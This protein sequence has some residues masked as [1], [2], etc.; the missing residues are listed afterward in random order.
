MACCYPGPHVPQPQSGDK[1][2]VLVTLTAYRAIETWNSHACET[3]AC[4]MTRSSS[5][6]FLGSRV[7]FFSRGFR[8]RLTIQS[9]AFKHTVAVI[10]THTHAR[11]VKRATLSQSN[12]GEITT[13]APVD[14]VRQA[15][16]PLDAD[17][18]VKVKPEHIR[19]SRW[20]KKTG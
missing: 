15:S 5:C 18:L 19:T 14:L 6:L 10:F 7:F 11:I 2:F 1:I 9:R 4:G 8:D 16:A 3:R 12:G 13:P 17:L 20:A